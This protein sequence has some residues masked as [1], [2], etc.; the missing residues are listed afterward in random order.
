MIMYWSGLL[1]SSPRRPWN[2]FSSLVIFWK[3]GWENHIRDCSKQHHG[4]TFETSRHATKLLRKINS[5]SPWRMHHRVSKCL[6]YKTHFDRYVHRVN[7]KFRRWP[8][9]VKLE[10]AIFFHTDC[11]ARRVW[12]RPISHENSD[13][14][15]LAPVA[16][17]NRA[18]H[19]NSCSSLA[20]TFF[21]SFLLRVFDSARALPDII[22]LPLLHKI[23]QISKLEIQFE[24]AHVRSQRKARKTE[25]KFEKEDY[26]DE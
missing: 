10:N 7:E 24:W 16:S 18:W 2:I 17:M 19:A 20:K 25:E 1:E 23:Y 14:N 3:S 21:S 13:R 8:P 6:P 22:T 15:S 26:Q 9:N 11:R 4:P 12:S 5:S